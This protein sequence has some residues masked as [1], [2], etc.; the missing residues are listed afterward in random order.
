[1]LI[2]LPLLGCPS[3]APKDDT[4]DTTDTSGALAGPSG[5]GRQTR[6]CAP[7]DGS[8]V[9][10]IIGLDGEGCEAS[11][12]GVPHVRITMWTAWPL[13]AGTHT[14]DASNSSAWVSADGTMEAAVTG[15]ELVLAADGTGSYTLDVQ[16]GETYEGTF[17]LESCESDVMC[18]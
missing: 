13:P 6:S 3:E 17:T 2:L 5:A 1:M 18:G 4:A 8:A 16:G 9:E 11:H 7:D 15:G 14:F 10:V 12:T